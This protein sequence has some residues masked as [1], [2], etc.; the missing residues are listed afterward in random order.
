MNNLPFNIAD[1]A[2]IV[3]VIGSALFALANGLV[4]SVLSLAGWIGAA[5]VTVWAFDLVR[6]YAFNLIGEKTLS[7]IAAGVVLFVAALVVFSLV[8]AAAGNAIRR[9]SLSALD[10]TL[11]FAFGLARGGL[12][13]TL[14]Y[15]GLSLLVPP[16]EH[17]PWITQAKAFPLVEQ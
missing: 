6:P 9:T 4:R 11:G 15:M 8:A 1:A 12:L 14:A 5:L 13:V 2:V 3:V 7:D 16:K 10:R 17:P